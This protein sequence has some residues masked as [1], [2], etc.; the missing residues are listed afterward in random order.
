VHFTH[1][2]ADDFGKMRRNII[3]ILKNRRHFIVKVI[4]EQRFFE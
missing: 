1:R 4:E 2:N 3:Q